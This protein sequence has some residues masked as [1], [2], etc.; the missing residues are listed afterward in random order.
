VQRQAIFEA[1]A[2]ELDVAIAEARL[3][4]AETEAE[5]PEAVSAPKKEQAAYLSLAQKRPAR[6]RPPRPRG[7]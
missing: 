4:L 7:G 3:A 6:R 5:G 1:A 2:A